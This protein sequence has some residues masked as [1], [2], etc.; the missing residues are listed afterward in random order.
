MECPI[1]L[2]DWNSETCIPLMLNCGHSYCCDCLILLLP[3]SCHDEANSIFQMNL[4]GNP[5]VFESVDNSSKLV[6]IEI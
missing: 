4:K 6:Q 3:K 1:C 5:I 2:N